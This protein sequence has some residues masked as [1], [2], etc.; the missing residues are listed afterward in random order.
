MTGRKSWAATA[1]AAVVGALVLGVGAATAHPDHGGGSGADDGVLDNAKDTDARGQHG[2]GAGHL[3]AS[4][5]N[6]RLVGRLT[7]RQSAEGRIA[8]VGALGNYAYLGAFAEPVCRRG[9]VYVVDISDPATPKEVAFVA[10]APDTYVGEGVQALSLATASF[11]G[12]LLAYNNEICGPHQGAVGGITLVDITNPRRPRKLVDGFGDVTNADGSVAARAHESHSVF[13]WT[14][15]PK[16]YAVFVDNEE[17]ADVDI[18]DITDPRKPV[19]ISETNLNDLGVAQPELG[20]TE[21]FHHDVVV[22]KIGKDWVMLVSYWDGGYV[23]LNVN[24]P[25]NPVYISDT[26]YPENDPERAKRGHLVTPEGNAHQAEFTRDSSMFVATD[27]DFSPFRLHANITSGPYAGHAFA[28]A[29]GTG[30]PQI[31]DERVVSGGTVFVGLACNRMPIP[32]P[33]PGGGIAVVERGGC[34]FSEKAQNVAAAGYTAGIVFNSPTGSPPCDALVTMLAEGSIPFAFVGRSD[35][36]RILGVT[37]GVE[38]C[39]TS[40]PPRGTTGLSVHLSGEF[41][42]WGYVH[43]YDRRSLRELGTYAI[44]ESQDRAFAYGFGDL[45]VH[46]VATDPD[47]DLA[48][49]SYYAGGLRVLAYGRSSGLT[50]VGHYIHPGGNNFWGVEVHKHPNGEKYVLASDRDTGL[51][52]FQYT[53]N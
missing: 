40:A 44:P 34:T 4:S 51:W 17:G 35:G 15:G 5:A 41:D 25:A 53:G 36:L 22:K 7:L 11:T 37:D 47:R 33:V 29:Q 46:E 28:A 27:E 31:D 48:Y 23:Q 3:P 10:A 19:L 30:V 38:D 16:A 50:E 42:G 39:A 26:D 8:D 32:P 9:G 43:L 2:P 14:T 12:D 21:S 52:I 45:S 6:V 13:V 18:A 1:V 24:D 49:L 20:L